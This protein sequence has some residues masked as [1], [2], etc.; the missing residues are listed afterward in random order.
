MPKFNQQIAIVSSSHT[1][2][3]SMSHQS[4]K[5][6]KRT[7]AQYYRGVRIVLVDSLADLERLVEWQPDLVFLGMKFIPT[8]SASGHSSRVWLSSYLEERGIACTGSG[9]AAHQLELSKPLAKQCILEAGLATAPFQVFTPTNLTLQPLEIDYPVFIKPTDRGGGLGVDGRSV[10][11]NFE[12]LSA[13]VSSIADAHGSDS[14]VERFLDGREFSVAILR[15]RDLHGYTAM[16]IELIAPPNQNGIRMLGGAMKSSNG[17]TATQV[18]DQFI[19]QRVNQLAIRAF[20]ALGGR[21]YGRI[22]IRLD[23]SGKPHF[24]EANLIPSLIDGYGSFPKACM[25]N[26]DLPYESMLIDIVQLGLE[27]SQT[28]H[29][30]DESYDSE[31]VVYA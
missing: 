24:L 12:Q 11:Y 13:K 22:D 6:I 15:D 28:G 18:T 14:L 9:S 20:E 30:T 1:R 25:I 7:L 21:D 16:P 27:R 19:R 31:A 5:A 17:E 8:T 29:Q 2:L 23:E 4:R 26:Q 10:A 3:S